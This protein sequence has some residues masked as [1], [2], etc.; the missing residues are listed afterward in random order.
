MDS[1]GVLPLR[2]GGDV[3]AMI[4]GSLGNRLSV[5]AQ[6]W[7][8]RSEGPIDLITISTLGIVTVGLFGYFEISCYHI[9]PC[10]FSLLHF[11]ISC[12]SRIYQDTVRC[13]LGLSK[14]STATA[15]CTFIP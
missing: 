5:V 2:N 6:L 10:L 11:T 13:V 14:P 15:Q 7:H 8:D 9:C 4:F 12:Y 3:A 1:S